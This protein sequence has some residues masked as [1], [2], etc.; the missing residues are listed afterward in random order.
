[1]RVNS[2]FTHS[3]PSLGFFFFFLI[4]IE[5]FPSRSKP[6]EMFTKSNTAM[7]PNFNR[8]IIININIFAIRCNLLWSV[9]PKHKI[10]TVK[11]LWKAENRYVVNFQDFIHCGSQDICK[12][13]TTV[14]VLCSILDLSINSNVFQFFYYVWPCKTRSK[15]LEMFTRSSMTIRPN[16]THWIIINL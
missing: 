3:R 13:K 2:N 6:L 8:W 1:M 11:S 10:K 14:D 12:T 16:F 5:E 4:K 15:P 9:G 7:R